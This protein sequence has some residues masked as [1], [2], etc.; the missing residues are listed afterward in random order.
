MKSYILSLHD[1]L[2]SNRK[3]IIDLV[4]NAKLI[5]EKIKASNSTLAR[6]YEHA[7]KQASELQKELMNHKDDLLYG[8]PYSLKDSISTKDIISTGGSNFLKDYVPPYSA[9]VYELLNQNNAVLISKS[10]CDEFGLGG[11]GRHSAIAKVSNILDPERIAGGSSSGSVNEVAAGMVAFSIGT[12]TGDS[13]RR[14]STFLGD[15]G[16][17]PTY[18]VVSRYGIY[19]YSPSLDHVGPITKTV[20]DSAIVMQAIAKYDERDFT[21]QKL[22][23]TNFY[24]NL[25]I[26][27]SLKICVFKNVEDMMPSRTKQIYLN[28]LEQIMSAGHTIVYKTLD[29]LLIESISVIYQIITYGEA[30]SC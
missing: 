22:T 28:T 1:D 14:P 26:K 4:N 23:D 13:I 30:C 3:T 19:P 16:F 17:K 6:N 27:K 29:N 10:N 15:V 9:Y 20:T 18:G 24:K 2:I 12:D 7:L 25:A 11:T 5:D 21:S 8:I